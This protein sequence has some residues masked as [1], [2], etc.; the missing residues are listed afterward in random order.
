MYIVYKYKCIV[1]F[2]NNYR[3]KIY[4]FKKINKIIYNVL[5]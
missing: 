4:I 5:K 2:V 1:I 3:K